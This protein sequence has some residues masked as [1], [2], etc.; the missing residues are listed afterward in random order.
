MFSP[1]GGFRF[2]LGTH[3]FNPAVHKASEKPSV[4]VGS[5]VHGVQTQVCE[6]GFPFHGVRERPFQTPCRIPYSGD[7]KGYF[8]FPR[9]C[10][11]APYP[12]S[13]LSI[14]LKIRLCHRKWLTPYFSKNAK[15]MTNKMPQPSSPSTG[16]MRE[17]VS[18]SRI[19]PIRLI[20]TIFI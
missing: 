15:G 13:S 1:D 20:R 5:Q 16:K 4:C 12:S 18:L 3:A 14:P 2:V 10:Q 8:P 19:Q 9:K 7:G 6:A 17:C 11:S